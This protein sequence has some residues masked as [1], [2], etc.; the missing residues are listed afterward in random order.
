MT[1]TQ[2][3]SCRYRLVEPRDALAPSPVL[4]QTRRTW[5]DGDPLL[6]SATLLNRLSEERCYLT[7]PGTSIIL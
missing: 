2:T 3:T 1:T 5:S 4:V 6:K 7:K